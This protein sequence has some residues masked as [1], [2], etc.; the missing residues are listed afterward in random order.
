MN[1]NKL[2]LDPDPEFWPNLDS[3]PEFWPSLNPGTDLG[4]CY[5]FW[6]KSDKTLNSFQMT[7]I[8]F[9]RRTSFLKYKAMMAPELSLFSGVSELLS[10]FFL[11]LLPP[12]YLIFTCVDP[13]RC[14][15]FGFGSTIRIKFRSESTTRSKTRFPIELPIFFKWRGASF[16]QIRKKSCRI[17]LWLYTVLVLNG[18]SKFLYNGWQIKCWRREKCVV[19]DI[20][21]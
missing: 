3:V 6:K 16:D 13:D 21:K 17:R 15:K 8:F 10:C 7:T 1:P 11:H 19:A 20:L 4:L 9:K 2:N 12:S 18:F 14:S 5:Q